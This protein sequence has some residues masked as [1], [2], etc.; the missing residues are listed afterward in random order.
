MGIFGVGAKKKSQQLQKTAYQWTEEDPKIEVARRRLEQG[1]TA[2]FVREQQHAMSRKVYVP[3]MVRLQRALKTNW[4]LF[5]YRGYVFNHTSSAARA[6]EWTVGW[7]ALLLVCSCRS[8]SRSRNFRRPSQAGDRPL[9]GGGRRV[10]HRHCRALQVIGAA[11]SPGR[12]LPR[13]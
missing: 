2:L 13:H 11:Q 5:R 6:W 7:M 12:H 10:H 9:L 8:T 4:L 1:G 3:P